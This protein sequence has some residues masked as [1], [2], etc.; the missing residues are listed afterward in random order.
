MNQMNREKMEDLEQQRRDD[1]KRTRKD[2][3]ESGGKGSRR[4]R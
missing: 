3:A 2:S 1:H 4:A